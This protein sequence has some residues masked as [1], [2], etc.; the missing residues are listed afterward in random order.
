[1]RLIDRI[2]S[3]KS[4]QKLLVSY[5]PDC[6]AVIAD[7]YKRVCEMSSSQGGEANVT[8]TEWQ[9]LDAC[10]CNIIT[11]DQH[12]LTDGVEVPYQTLVL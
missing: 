8:N 6:L 7:I 11:L 5:F 12:R 2:T 10:I 4:V 9:S 3:D 1:M